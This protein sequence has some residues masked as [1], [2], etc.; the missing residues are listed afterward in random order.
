MKK[1]MC[2]FAEDMSKQ[3]HCTLVIKSYSIYL[4]RG[5]GCVAHVSCCRDRARLRSNG[6]WHAVASRA[7]PYADR[8][9]GDL[10]FW[11]VTSDIKDLE[12][13]AHVLVYLLET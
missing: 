8:H 9:A 11:G 12:K 5:H 1:E 3:T 13:C 4:I 7:Y 6:S 2:R 10:G